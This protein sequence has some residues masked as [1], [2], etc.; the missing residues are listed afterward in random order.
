MEFLLETLF[1]F[2][3]VCPIDDHLTCGISEDAIDEYLDCD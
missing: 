2:L 3:D 1:A